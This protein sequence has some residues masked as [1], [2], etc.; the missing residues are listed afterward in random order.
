MPARQDRRHAGRRR[1]LSP[2]ASRLRK[3][4]HPAEFAAQHRQARGE[5][6]RVVADRR[7][8]PQTGPGQAASPSTRATTCT[9]SCRTMLPERADVEL[10]AAAAQPRSEL[11]GEVDFGQQHALRAPS[12]S[13]HSV[14]AGHAA[15]PAPARG[16]AASSIRRSCDSGP[17]ATSMRVGG[18]PRVELEVRVGAQRRCFC[19]KARVRFMR[20]LGDVGVVVG[21]LVA[22][23][24]VAGRARRGCRRPAARRGAAATSSGGMIGSRSPKCN[25]SGALGRS[26]RSGTVRPP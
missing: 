10:V 2:R 11:A 5:G 1:E 26:C 18:Q 7:P 13:I 23:E 22:V 25:S 12:R 20:L 6:R 3:R 21:A 9:C 15:A 17:S 24:A 19:R 14:G 16:N 8:L 4:S